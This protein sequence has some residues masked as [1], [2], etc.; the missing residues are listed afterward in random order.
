[1]PE[2]TATAAGLGAAAIT[3]TGSIM[4]MQYDALTIGLAGGV[5]AL[6]H[7][8]PM[9][10]HLR[11]FGSV[12]SSALMGGLF[13]PVASAAALNYAPWISSVSD[14]AIRLVFAFTIGLLAQV[15]IPVAMNALKR[16][17]DAA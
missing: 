4:G 7:L 1:M 12:A 5:V 3:L 16:K 6:M 11:K 15:A 13:S 2:P 17:G 8:P 10:S 9:D 14:V